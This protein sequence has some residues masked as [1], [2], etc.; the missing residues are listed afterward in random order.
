MIGNSDFGTTL[1]NFLESYC[2][3]CHGPEKQK[4]DRR[5]D[6]MNLPI[7]DS[8]TLIELQDILDILNLGEMPPEEEEK[9]PDDPEMLAMIAG[10]TETLEAHHALLSSTNRET[11]LRR[12][13]RRE[14]LNSIRDLLSMNISLFDP[15]QSF[16]R[17]EEEHHVD[18]LGDQL[19]TSS[20][21]LD[22][23]VEAADA[24]IEKVFATTG[25]PEVR[26]WHFTGNFRSLE[27]LGSTMEQ[28][29]NY[30]YIA[31]YEVPTSQRHEGAYGTI[32]DFLDGVP[33]DG[34]YRIRLLAEAKNRIHNHIARVSTTNPNQLHELAIVPGD[35][36]VGELG[37]PQR[38]EPTLASF[39]LPD[40]QPG[41]Y[42]ATVW[43]DAGITPRFIFP[44]GTINL[45]SAFQPVFD[46]IAP[47]LDEELV[48]D[49]GN[50]K[51]VTLKYGELP[52]I[53]IHEVEITGPLNDQWPS[54]SQ[55]SVL[56]G[57]PF[58]SLRVK[59]LVGDFATRAYRRPATREEKDQL[60]SF[61][62]KR[63]ESGLG[64]FQAF[65]DTLKR[66]LCSPG[67]LYL[68][69]P[70]D[71]AGQLN[72]YALA[73]RLSYF[74]WSSMPD[75]IL[76][77]LAAKGSLGSPRVLKTQV[78]RMLKDE[79]SEAFVSN[80]A[81]LVL[82]LKDLGSQPPDRNKF[83]IYYQRNLQKYMYE[84][85]L[86][87]VRHLLKENRKIT[88]LI[89]ADYTFIN[90]PL[91]ELYGYEGIHGLHFQKITLP[92][93]RRSGV[94]GHASILTVTANG[95][96]TSPVIRGVWMLENILGSPPSPPPPDVPPFDPDTR[97]ALSLRD[98]LVKHRKN[99]TC[100]ECHRKIDPLGFALESFDPI[101][102][103]R[104][105]YNKDVP[106]DC[107]GTLPDGSSFNS[108]E[109]FKDILVGRSDQII[110][111]ITSKLLTLG[112]GR[113]MEAADRREIDAIIEILR[114][115]GDGFRDLV[116][117]TVL[118]EIFRSH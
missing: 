13:N 91:A 3:Q 35:K 77:R 103:W 59:K 31:L 116:E 49:F 62:E 4:G 81:D 24:I 18:T 92:D 74:L 11:V 41:W 85:T 27:G 5:L 38:I 15:A 19:V 23:Y 64:S 88:E 100:F 118:S 45:R 78:R 82:T 55:Q 10:L 2:I 79:R 114:D 29:C 102:Q 111:A 67:F 37:I 71:E 86:Q 12:L 33:S 26:N 46:K 94:L 47:T 75:D 84:E 89:N 54:A 65:K 99:P 39:T 80:F 6:S 48:N 58:S 42:E 40:D 109:E 61:Y 9:R 72:D 66:V 21:L 97:G 93:K 51:L 14:Y 68:Q 113:R 22:Q 95:I 115:Q 87:L 1:T 7:K 70:A 69:E 108:I 53:R 50:R 73:S 76:L 36:R 43:L 60:M 98:Q 25:K 20:Y 107:S 17:D 63:M 90:E 30:E 52:H 83:A 112:T 104:S 16:P 101:G 105:S 44:N 28:L 96:D 110:R 34:H 32:Y 117:L 56:Q 57:K 8:A 106:V